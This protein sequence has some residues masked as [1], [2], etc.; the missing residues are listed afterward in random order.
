MN[1]ADKVILI[2]N[3]ALEERI[4]AYTD[5]RDDMSV[6]ETIDCAELILAKCRSGGKTGIARVAFYPPYT[7]FSDWPQGVEMPEPR[8]PAKPGKS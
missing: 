5:D 4:H 1:D 8:E 6:D 7:Q 2:Y 3:P